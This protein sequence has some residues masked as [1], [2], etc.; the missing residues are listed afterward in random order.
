MNGFDALPKPLMSLA[1]MDGV[2]DMAFRQIVRRLNPE[3][4]LYSEFT[5][6]E[7]MVHSPF[8]RSRLEFKPSELPYVVQ[9]FGRDPKTFTTIAA[10]LEDLGITGIDINMGCPSKRVVSGGNGAALI[11]E[12]D[13]AYQIVEACVKA[14]RL[15]VSVKTRLGYA[16]ADDL[17]PFVKGLESSGV[18]MLTIHGRTAKMGYRGEADWNP[19]YEAKQALSIPVIG[20]GDIK[21]LEQGQEQSAKLDG[22]MVGRAAVGNPWV[23]WEQ[24]KR[25]QI[26]LADKVDVMLE[27]F[28]LLREF[29]PEHKALVEFRKHLG[30]YLSGF[31]DA[32][33]VRRTLMEA[34]SEKDFTQRALAL[35]S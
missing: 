9:I 14:T 13:L 19:I 11:K 23:F 20:N 35:A 12:P 30:G 17:I 3:V 26:T 4:L 7:G 18:K 34:D 8:V 24:E 21:T 6:V 1:P 28:G 27:H 33:S 5:N 15:P 31:R 10:E 22:F 2:T 32:K 16:Q 29:Q 25:D